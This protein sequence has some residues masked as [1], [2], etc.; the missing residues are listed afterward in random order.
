[1]VKWKIQV[2][3][4]PVIVQGRRSR[5]QVNIGIPKYT[6]PGGLF[7][8]KNGHPDADIYV[9]IGIQVPIFTVNMGIPL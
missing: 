1:M 8:R 5:C 9:N 6:H 4:Q 2:L 3:R 7:S